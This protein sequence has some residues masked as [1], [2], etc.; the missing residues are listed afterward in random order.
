[1]GY[2]DDEPG[3]RPWNRN[4]IFNAQARHKKSVTLDMTVP[5]GQ[6]VFERLIKNSDGLIE[7]N[8]AISM[9]RL[10]VT[11][12]R[13][14]EINPRLILIR[15]PAFGIEGPYKNYRTWGNH[16]EAGC[17]AVVAVVLL[18]RLTHQPSTSRAL[19]LGLVIGLGLWIGFSSGFVAL[20]VGGALQHGGVIAREYGLPCVSGLD[21]VTERVHDGQM[22]E[23]DGSNGVVRLLTPNPEQDE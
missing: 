14:S 17:V 10:G 11:W 7:N 23:V 21:G 6:E 18:T 1:M 2:P 3:Q 13:L 12:E 19:G 20:A 4:A 22:I 9:E 5:E 16:M 8:V 15:Q